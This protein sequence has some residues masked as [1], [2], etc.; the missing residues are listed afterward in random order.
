[1]SI[2][3]CASKYSTSYVPYCVYAVTNLECVICYVICNM[4]CNSDGGLCNI[5]SSGENITLILVL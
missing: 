4:R 5:S 2:W 3:H 1:M